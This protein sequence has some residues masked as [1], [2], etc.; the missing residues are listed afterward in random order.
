MSIG[1]RLSELSRTGRLVE[2]RRSAECED[3]ELPSARCPVAGIPMAGSVDPS[4][5][6]RRPT[7]R[8]QR[9]R[10]QDRP[11]SAVEMRPAGVP[12]GQESLAHDQYPDLNEDEPLDELIRL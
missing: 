10:G 8:Q 9:S 12:Y 4:R 5:N 6:I 7:G 3:D 1:D 2:A 11:R